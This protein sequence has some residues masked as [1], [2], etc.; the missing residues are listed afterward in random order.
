MNLFM[1]AGSLALEMFGMLCFL[2]ASFPLLPTSR[3][4]PGARAVGLEHGG[5]APIAP[6]AQLPEPAGKV[7]TPHIRSRSFSFASL[8]RGL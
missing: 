3:P 5:S 8:G 7:P 4:H 2:P 6:A 1:R